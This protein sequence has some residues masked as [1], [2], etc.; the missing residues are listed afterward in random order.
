MTSTNI[1]ALR[2]AKGMTLAS[3]S[4]KV[5]VSIAYLS[6]I[7]KG[8]RHGSPGTISRIA[9]ALGVAVSDLAEKEVG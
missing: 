1:R 7:E 8:N 6:D 9:D 3:L 4:E 5:G 2:K